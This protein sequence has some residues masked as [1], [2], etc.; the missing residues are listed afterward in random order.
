MIT[1]K[2]LKDGKKCTVKFELPAGTNA[3]KAYLCGDF[4]DWTPEEMKHFKNGSFSISVKLDAN[5]K[6]QFRYRLDDERWENDSSADGVILN[7]FGSQDS[8]LQL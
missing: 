7:P 6:Y 4:N 8:I 1:K 3:S 5:R 2:Y